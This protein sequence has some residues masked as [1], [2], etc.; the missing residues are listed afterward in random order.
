MEW[1]DS[2][3]PTLAIRTIQGGQKGTQAASQ[4]EE[5]VR[6]FFSIG[7]ERIQDRLNQVALRRTAEWR[8]MPQNAMMPGL[9]GVTY[10]D[11]IREFKLVES[12]S[13][14]KFRTM[15]VYHRNYWLSV[16]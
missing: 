9:L 1:V 10:G 15:S 13:H 6:I 14:P 5:A 8:L 2:T 16:C 4:T 3:L 12:S 7:I 11:G